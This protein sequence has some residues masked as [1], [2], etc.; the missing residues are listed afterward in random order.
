MLGAWLLWDPTNMGQG[1]MLHPP[2]LPSC[3]SGLTAAPPALPTPPGCLP[4]SGSQ[5]GHAWLS[6]ALGGGGW[7]GL[8]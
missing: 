6:C 3:P 4:D 5:W 7:G 2:P 1:E 8:H